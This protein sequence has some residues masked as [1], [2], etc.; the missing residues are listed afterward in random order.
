[1]QSKQAADKAVRREVPKHDYMAE[2]CRKVFAIESQRNRLGLKNHRQ[3]AITG[4][5]KV[6]LIDS[7][8]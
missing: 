6:S 1:M 4:E 8:G 3:R 7:S 2:S 5:V